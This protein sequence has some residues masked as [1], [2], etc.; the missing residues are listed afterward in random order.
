MVGGLDMTCND[1]SRSWYRS[2]GRA[3]V[4]VG[5]IVGTTLAPGAQAQADDAP[6]ILKAMSDYVASQKN[7]ILCK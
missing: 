4:L 5:M 6:Q 3:I 1:L 7:G 2:F